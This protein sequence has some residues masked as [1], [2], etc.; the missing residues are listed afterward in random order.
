MYQNESSNKN[1]SGDKAEMWR[2]R[3]TSAASTQTKL[4]DKFNEWYKMMYAIRD[5]RNMAKW[6]SKIHI[7]ILSTKAW[8]MIAKFVQQEPGFEVTVKDEESEEK[9]VDELREV[10]DKVQSRLEYEYRNPEFDEPMRDKLFAP[11]VDAVVTGTG[12]AK[13]PWVRKNKKTYKHATKKN[14]ELDYE[15]DEVTSFSVGYNELEPVNIFNVFI[16]PSA[17][18]LQKAPWIIISERK[19]LEELKETNRSKGVEVYKNLDKLR[20]VKST[21][22][23]FAEQKKARQNLTTEIDPYTEDQTVQELEVFECYDRDKN[24]ICTFVAT[25]NASGQESEWIPIREQKNP[26]WHGKFPLVAFYIRRRPFHFWGESVFETTYRLQAAANDIFNHY[27]DNWN[28]SVDGGIMIEE[29]SQVADFL[30]EPGFELIYRGEQPKQFSFPTPDPNQLTMVMNQVEKAVENATISNYATGTPVSGLDKTQGTARGT[31]AILEAATDMIQFMRDNFTS[32][33]RQIGEMWLSN[34]RQFMTEPFE[35]EDMKNNQ[36]VYKQLTPEELQLQ[37]ELQINDMSMQPISDQQKRENF[38]AYQNRMIE[39]Q[40]A[41]I[42]QSQLTGDQNQILFI[43]WHEQAKLTAKHFNQRNASKQVLPNEQALAVQTEQA[44][45]AMQQS[46]LAAQAQLEE[47]E[48]ANS[49]DEMVKEVADLPDDEQLAAAEQ[50][51]YELGD[52][53]IGGNQ[54]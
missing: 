15:N 32:S 44:A 17:T 43:D 36:I 40:T 21:P 14:G 49:M 29:S 26:Y 54:Q 20:G 6:R 27:M 50:A 30:V 48:R 9:P 5:E 4:F 3:Y 25:G 39:L 11:L 46:E 45:A 37:M 33:I 47:E 18:S 41:S 53:G 42:N 34:N 35:Y 12:L 16:A 22:D 7:P 2:R 1:L 28:L 8:N 19:T 52:F 24:T 31:M 38:L 10:A 13:V 23:R 51:L